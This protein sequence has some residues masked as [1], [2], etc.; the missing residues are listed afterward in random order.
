MAN[1][2]IYNH[3]WELLHELEVEPGVADHTRKYGM[4]AS[5]FRDAD[6]SWLGYAPVGDDDIGY[7]M[8]KVIRFR[9]RFF[10]WFI[11]CGNKW[12]DSPDREVHLHR[13]SIS[14]FMDTFLRKVEPNYY[15]EW[16]SRMSGY[17][18]DKL[19]TE[20]GEDKKRR[21]K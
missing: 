5:A 9:H 20:Y 6:A 7:V 21:A 2:K 16:Y 1:V 15:K 13:P 3:R 4:F 11:V 12:L 14:S 10:G 8:K 19:N 18:W 17:F